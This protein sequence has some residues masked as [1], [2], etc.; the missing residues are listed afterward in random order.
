LVDEGFQ[1]TVEGGYLIVDRVPYVVSAGQVGWGA[2]ICAYRNVDGV[3]QLDGDHQCWFTGTVP[4][5]AEGVSLANTLVSN[6]QL[7]MIGG[8]QVHCHLSNKPDPIGAFFDNHYNKIIHYV[9][10]ITRHA[11]DVDP[12][13]S[14]TSTGSFHYRQKPSVFF[15]PNDAIALGGLDAYADKVRLRRVCIVGAGGTGSYLLDALAKEEIEQV[16]IYDHDVI[17]P[18]NVYRM[19]SAMTPEDAFAQHPKAPWLAARYAVMRHGITGHAVRIDACNTHLL[20]GADFVFIAFDHGPSRGLIARFL[21]DQKIPFIDVGI[22]VDKVPEAT[23]LIARARVTF[24]TPDTAALLDELPIADDTADAVYNNIQVLELNALNAML[25]V[26]RFKQYLGFYAA[27]E[28][29]SVI[30]YISSWNMLRV[31]G[32]SA[33]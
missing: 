6:A 31:S 19:P 27:E 15:Y 23:A 4:C 2:L 28:T 1:V 12:T 11:R 9:R 26:I 20:A 16:D 17:E 32:T 30:K 8:R 13:V 10:K 22:G 25:A 21:V 24:V 33:E 18:K 29:P 14:A 3:P 7:Q 5:T